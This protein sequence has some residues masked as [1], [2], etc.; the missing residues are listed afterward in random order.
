MIKITI[1]LLTVVFVLQTTLSARADEGMWL[2][3]FLKQ[4]NEKDMKAQGMKLSA[5]DIYNANKSSLK[6]AIVLFGPGCTGEII[7]NEGLM[8]TNHHCGYDN[9]QE[10][11]SVENDYLTKGFWAMNREQE[12]KN[13]GLTATIVVRMEDVTQEVLRGTVL[14]MPEAEREKITSININ[15][16]KAKAVEGTHYTAIIKPFFYGT[17]YYLFVTEVFKDVRL[18]GAPPS[19]IGKFGGDTDNWMWPRH[20]G[21]FSLFRIYADKDNKPA[22]YSKDN[23]PYK[24]KK[25]L[26]ISTQGIKANDFTMVLGFP[27]RTQEYLSS[28]ALNIVTK[29]SNPYK[30]ALRTQRLNIID[31]AMRSSDTIRIQYAAKQSDIANAWKKW[32]GELKGLKR[33]KVISK[34]EKLEKDFAAWANA[35]EA[36]KVKYGT[37]LTDLQKAYSD[38]DRII[39]NVDYQRDAVYGSDILAYASA[40]K[41]MA[42]SIATT[43]NPDKFFNILKVQ[44]DE[45]FKDYHLPTDKK[46]FVVCMTAYYRDIKPE[47]HP[48]FFKKVT[49]Q[50]GGDFGKYAD[51]AYANSHLVSPQKAAKLWEELRKKNTKI[52]EEDPIYILWKSCQEHYSRNIMPAYM[53][54]AQ[55]IEL[56]SRLYVS[57]LREMQ[58]NKKFY[59]DANSTFRVAY[60]KVNGYKPAD[61]VEYRYLTTLDGVMEK[62]NPAVD[63][64]VVPQKLK[65]LYQKKDFGNYAEKGKMPVAFMASNHTTGGNS[66]SPV[67]NANGE[68]IGTNFDRVWEGTMSDLMYDPEQC[69]NIVLDIRYTL[70][71]ID[72]FAGAG[73]LIKEMQIK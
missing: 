70:F 29:K 47:H 42:D 20:T 28:Y 54:A 36:R 33:L 45:F 16:L 50:F 15:R 64:F 10:H 23:V 19:S 6:D 24:P 52:L 61:G 49:E 53:Q 4:L 40:Y 17:E 13:P 48:A 21:D 72:K 11:S 39:L 34:K 65:D 22:N 60:G 71:V 31:E 35:D 69:R 43:R 8:L 44:T 73:H 25:V 37:V 68:L 38:I 9:I 12:L 1:R 57:G 46:L 18:V 51:Y 62:E 41:A 2:P 32:S 67:L 27:G 59:P 5:D 55:Q 56:S 7:S 3:L 63:E 14:G 26:T 58:P 30:I 66:G